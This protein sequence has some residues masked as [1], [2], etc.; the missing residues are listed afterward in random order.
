MSC[1]VSRGLYRYVPI[2]KLR[3]CRKRKLKSVILSFLFFRKEEKP[4]FVFWQNRGITYF[5]LRMIYF[6]WRV[7]I[8][9][10][11]SK[12][13]RWGTKNC[14]WKK[15]GIRGFTFLKMGVSVNI[16]TICTYNRRLLT[17]SLCMF[18]NGCGLEGR[19]A[20]FMSCSTWSNWRTVLSPLQSFV[21]R[22]WKNCTVPRKQLSNAQRVTQS[23]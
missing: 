2:A 8:V 12:F 18:N 3:L 17:V 23:L 9:W 10:W 4:I 20:A 6:V 22:F 5:F 19:S 14:R 7:I 16:C 1:S 21:R 11:G 15:S 13:C